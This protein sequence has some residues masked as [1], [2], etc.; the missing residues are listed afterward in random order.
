MYKKEKCYRLF[1]AMW[2][3]NGVR[4]P[5]VE[6]LAS[7]SHPVKC[8][9]MQAENLHITLHFIGRVS[10]PVKECLHAAA[11]SVN[12]KA[13]QLNLDSFGHF[14]KAKIF[15]MGCRELP[16]EAL[17]LHSKLGAALEACGYQPDKRRYSPHVTLMRKC[18]IPFPPQYDFS[19]PWLVD[20]FVLVES[21]THQE[22]VEYRVIEKYPLSPVQP[23]C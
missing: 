4:Q 13:F 15:W 2:P 9:V 6:T 14:R 17:Q 21:V 12:A 20:Q 18:I 1:F 8:R 3:S 19:I 10:E 16:G 7:L 22:G 23:A 5:I 11:Q